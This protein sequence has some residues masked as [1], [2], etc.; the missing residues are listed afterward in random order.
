M[1]SIIRK[2]YDKKINASGLAVFRVLYSIVHIGEVVQMF[3]FRHLIYDKIPYVEL[4]EIDYTIPMILWIITLI[5]LMFGLFTRTVTIINY[6]FSLFLIST[7][8]SYEYHMFYVYLGV[9]FLLIFTSISKVGSLDALRLKLKHSNTRI[10]YKPPRNTSVL[11]YYAY[12][13]LGIAFVYFDS[14]F[15]KSASHNWLSGLGMWLPASLPHVTHLSS[16]TIFS[17]S[18]VLA[19]LLGYLTFAFEAIF[20]FTFFRK[21]FRV[22]LLIVGIGLHIGIFI[23]FPIPWFGLGVSALYVMMIPVSFWTRIHEKLILTT[24]KLTFFYDEECPLC[25]RTKLILNHLDFFKAIEFKGVQT[26]GYEDERLKGI[27]KDELLDNIYSVTN[28]NKVYSAVDTYKFAFKRIPLL[29]PLGI[30]MSIPG[31]YHL[32]K[33]IYKKV[34]QNRYVERCTEENCGFTPAAFP[35]N[36]D[37]I[38]LLNNLQVKDLKIHLIFVGFV[39]VCLLQINVT[40]NSLLIENI[41]TQIGIKESPIEKFTMNISKPIKKLSQSF[42]GITTHAVF[43]DSHFDDYNHIVAIEAHLDDGRK[44]WL[45][46]IDEKGT[47][48]HFIYSFNWVKWTFRVNNRNVNKENLTKGIRDFTAFW[49]HKNNIDLNTTRFV[50]KVKKVEVPREWKENFLSK[51]IQ[52]P[53]IEGGYVEWKDNKF[54]SSIKDIESL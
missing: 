25:N 48:G 44:I 42:F 27:S 54:Y 32:A 34:A 22:P 10:T 31:I 28:K 12:V 45:P 16:E 35:E 14:I 15:Y 5:F 41:K 26:Y 6:L 51:Q 11:N 20:L 4:S 21:R 9:N 7:I 8:S 49:A 2:L 36:P 13:L 18:K 52:K 39:I 43:M 33:A 30:L 53:W 23:V 24:P 19:L 47:P 17:N 1:K 40:Y 37:D 29:F 38:K 46:I 3:Y 50:V